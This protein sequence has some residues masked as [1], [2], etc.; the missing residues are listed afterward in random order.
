MQSTD[1]IQDW[2]IHVYYDDGSKSTAEAVRDEVETGLPGLKTG[3]MHDKPVGPHP[4]PSF[5][6][7]VPNERLAEVLSLIHISEP[8]R[9][10]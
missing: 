3:S 9:P 4:Q 5:Q 2:H 1:I 10:Y 7:L 8:T 6:V